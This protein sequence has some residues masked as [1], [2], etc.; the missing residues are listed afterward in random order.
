[1][2]RLRFIGEMPISCQNGAK[3]ANAAHAAPQPLGCSHIRAVLG[4]KICCVWLWQAM[5]NQD[6]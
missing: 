4:I 1:M 2:E 3:T 6:G 5:R